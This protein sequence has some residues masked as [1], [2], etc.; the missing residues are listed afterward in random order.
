[1][2]NEHYLVV[3]A[4][5]SNH[6]GILEAFT[7]VSKQCGCNI[8]ESRLTS[9]GEECSLLFH[10]AGTWNT[11]A[12]VEATLP[13]VAQQYAVAIQTK[14]TLPKTQYSALPYQVQVVAQDKSGILNDL[15]SFFAQENVSVENMESQI[16]VAKNQTQMTQITLLVHIPS[17]RSI[18]NLREKF[19]VYCEDRNLDAILEPYK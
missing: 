17:K 9:V 8:L 6:P 4:L 10:L 3:T 19:I 14:R 5:G 11:I 15:A 12:K 13:M 7:K 2:Q 1:M 16:Y 18:A